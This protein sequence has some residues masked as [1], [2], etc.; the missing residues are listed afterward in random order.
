MLPILGL[1]VIIVFEIELRILQEVVE[2]H[3]AG[4]SSV[5][6]FF[7]VLLYLSPRCEVCL[8]VVQQNCF[9]VSDVETDLVLHVEH[10]QEGQDTIG[11][12]FALL[13]GVFIEEH[14]VAEAK[15]EHNQ[16]LLQHYV[17]WAW[18]LVVIGHRITHVL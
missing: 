7:I 16:P 13:V 18:T 12:S 6:K 4:V 10:G 11:Q 3:V 1:E 17:N 9:C 5:D 8:S 2:K 15:R 14:L